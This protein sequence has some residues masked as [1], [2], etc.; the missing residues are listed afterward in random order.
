MKYYFFIFFSFF[1]L[2]EIHSQSCESLPIKDENKTKKL[3]KK[4]RE[5]P[6]SQKVKG[7]DAWD[8]AVYLLN[9]KDT[10]H[11]KWFLFVINKSRKSY[12]HT[13]ISSE[14][15]ELLYK[16]GLSYFYIEDYGSAE[17]FLTKSIKCMGDSKCSKYFLYLCNLKQGK[18]EEAE[19]WRKEFDGGK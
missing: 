10:L 19:K 9:R 6:I 17:N 3:E 8:V 15:V 13:K 2:C 5:K 1:F 12:V 4:F 18:N 11:K 16:I 7:F 14:K